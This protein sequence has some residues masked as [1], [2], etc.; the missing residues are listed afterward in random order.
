MTPDQ[1][2]KSYIGYMK[3]IGASQV[4]SASLLPENDPSTLF[5]GSGMQ[6]MV[7]YLLG[8]KH[9]IGSEITDI[10]KCL[11]TVDIEEVGDMSHLTFFEMIGRWEFRANE[12]DYKKSRLMLFGI[13]RLTN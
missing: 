12:N 6:P 1:L 5:T 2:R 3:R 8:E 9:P 4:P 13:G 10:Q 7:P 11:R